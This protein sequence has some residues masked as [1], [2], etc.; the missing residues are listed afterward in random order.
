MLTAI[1]PK[2][3]KLEGLDKM[4]QKVTVGFKCDP[5][6]KLALARQAAKLGLTLSEFTENL[7]G[8]L[9]NLKKAHEQEIDEFNEKL[10]FYENDNLLRLFR[11]YKAQNVNFVN[12]DGI[13][14]QIEIKQPRDIYTILINSYKTK[15]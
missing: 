4:T 14:F 8:N 6:T 9:E 2:A 11:K 7:I 15:E 13:E 5:K 3:L 12:P 10:R 1:N